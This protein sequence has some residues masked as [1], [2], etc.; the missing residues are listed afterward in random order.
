MPPFYKLLDTGLL[1]S[2][3]EWTRVFRMSG[4]VDDV[5]GK[6]EHTCPWLLRCSKMPVLV[7]D[8]PFLTSFN[9]CLAA[10]LMRCVD[11]KCCNTETKTVRF[12]SLLSSNCRIDVLLFGVG[13]NIYLCAGGEATGSVNR[14]E[15]LS[16]FPTISFAQSSERPECGR[17]DAEDALCCHS[18]REIRC[19]FFPA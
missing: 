10:F 6:Y 14:C 16:A 1:I 7:R 4:S 2:A 11:G 5:C 8:P 19:W 12:C 3:D 18:S 17:I 13:Y 15:H 9:V